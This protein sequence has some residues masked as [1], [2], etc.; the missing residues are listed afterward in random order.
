M[1][2]EPVGTLKIIG[3]IDKIILNAAKASEFAALENWFYDELFQLAIIDRNNYDFIEINTRSM[4]KKA[5]S[6][7]YPKLE[8]ISKLHHAKIPLI[9]NSD[10]HQPSELNGS[11]STLHQLLSNCGLESIVKNH[12]KF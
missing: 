5:L 12:A 4:Y 11:Y 1:I 7:P 9:I 8:F 6:N 2:S 3:H 10:A